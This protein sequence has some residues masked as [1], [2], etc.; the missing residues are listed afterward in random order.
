MLPFTA[1]WLPDPAR[2]AAFARRYAERHFQDRD[3]LFRAIRACVTPVFLLVRLW[4][5]GLGAD[6]MQALAVAAVT[7][8]VECAGFGWQKDKRGVKRTAMAVLTRIVIIVSQVMDAAAMEVV[9]GNPGSMFRFMLM[10]SGL[11]ALLIS[12]AGVPLLVKHHLAVSVT[13]VV[14]MAVFAVPN[15]CAAAFSAPESGPIVLAVWRFINAVFTGGCLENE[16]NPPPLDACWSVVSM[17]LFVL[18][19]LAPSF[20]MWTVEYEDRVNFTRSGE[21][22]TEE[23]IRK[24]MLLFIPVMGV[25]WLL[26]N[27]R[28]WM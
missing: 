24:Q 15:Q 5:N 3:L 1:L 7:V 16:Y 2:E 8:A 10:Q 14:A 28:V 19:L 25:T 12:N 27:F 23:N 26:L 11:V 6:G 13:T 9:V 20:A 21:L 22:L 4:Q 18:G 17:S